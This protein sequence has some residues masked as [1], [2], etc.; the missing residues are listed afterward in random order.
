MG[1]LVP[2]LS[3]YYTFWIASDDTSDLYLSTD[4]S[5]TN[6]RRIAYVKE[7][8]KV[9]EWDRKPNQKSIQI[10]LAAGQRYYVEA[11]HKQDGGTSNVSVAWQPPGGTRAVISGQYLCP[12]PE[13][14]VAAIEYEQIVPFTSPPLP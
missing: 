9:H 2:T 3:G 14:A 8:T 7:R 5:P 13:R 4:S 11:L 12:I 10:Y 6:A 1:Y